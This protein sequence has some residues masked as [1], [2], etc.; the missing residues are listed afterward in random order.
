MRRVLVPA[1][2]AVAALCAVASP[3][4]AHNVLISSDPPRGAAL[5]SGPDTV[6]LT[7]NAPVQPADVNQVSVL[8]P[9]QT[10]WAAGQV[11]VNGNV[12]TAPVRPLGPAGEYTI[13]Y[14]VLSADGHSVSEEIPFTLTRAGSGTPAT[15]DAATSA[16]APEN[17]AQDTSDGS[18]GVPVWVWI[19][20]AV[21]LLGIGLVVALRTGKQHT[22][23]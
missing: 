3:A 14:R 18:D 10:Q 11:Q 9:G 15:G 20:G 21:V 19:A 16:N 2:L 8:G 17:G 4:M 13:G 7:F 22:K 12:V 23:P 1:L 5:E 6:T